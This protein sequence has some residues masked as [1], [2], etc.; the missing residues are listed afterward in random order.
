MTNELK[1]R[2]GDEK[3]CSFFLSLALGE[4]DGLFCS[5]HFS[6]NY[7]RYC[8]LPAKAAPRSVAL[9]LKTL[10][11]PYSGGPFS[12]SFDDDART[13]FWST[14]LPPRGAQKLNKVFQGKQTN[15]DDDCL[16]FVINLLP[17]F[18]YSN[19]HVQ[20]EIGSE[21]K[22]FMAI[23]YTGQVGLKRRFSPLAY[24][25]GTKFLHYSKSEKAP[26]LHQ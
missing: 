25:F 2:A 5:D 11:F 15:D 20:L 1:K 18:P 7:A 21:G 9:G 8:L 22:S 3:R 4:V 26:N 10:S 13:K 19:K 17:R 14:G 24:D 6:P 12:F 23:R 16:N